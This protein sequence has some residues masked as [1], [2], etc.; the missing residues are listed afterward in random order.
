[1]KPPEKKLRAWRFA[2]LLTTYWCNAR[3]AFCY[4]WGGPDQG[5]AMPPQDA[6]AYWEQLD[7][8][9]AVDGRR[10]QI[11]IAGG[12][13]FGDFENLLGI[14]HSARRAGLPPAQ[15]VETNA[16]WATEDDKTRERLTALREA[17]LPRADVSTDVFHQEFVD[18][19]RVRRC[20]RIAREVFGPEGV[21]VRW[22]AFLDD[23]VIV[24]DMPSAQRQRAFLDALGKIPERMTGR[25]AFEVAPLLEQHPPDHFR[26]AHCLRELLKSKHVHVGPDGLT[27]PGVCSGIILG[28]ARAEPLDVMW[29]RLAETWGDEPIVAPLVHEGPLGLMELARQ[30]GYEPRPQGYA[31]KCHLCT[32]VRQFLFDRGAYPDRLGPDACYAAATGSGPPLFGARSAPMT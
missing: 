22:E 24:A 21:R 4:V 7:R 3:C 14:L 28:H 6:V 10:V 15:K 17:G 8:V 13:P 12:E 25:A 23:P 5:G 29:R 18:I 26:G 1:M 2:G 9:A 30:H 19:E 16:Y 32:H 11:H 20:V 31:T 27:F